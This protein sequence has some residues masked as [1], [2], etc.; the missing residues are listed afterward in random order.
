MVLELVYKGLKSC[1]YSVQSMDASSRIT[2][3]LAFKR[4]NIATC[5]ILFMYL[6]VFKKLSI[7][8]TSLVQGTRVW[9]HLSRPIFRSFRQVFFTF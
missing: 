3:W 8:L 9:W 7:M 5:M 1:M 4:L 6:N 2:D